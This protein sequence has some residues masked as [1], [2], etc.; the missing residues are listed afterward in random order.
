M[1]CGESEGVTV[2][3]MVA[4]EIAGNNR[5]SKRPSRIERSASEIVPKEQD[6]E[7][8]EP[9]A[10]RGNKGC[11]MLLASQPSLRKSLGRQSEV[12]DH[13]FSTASW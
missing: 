11:T 13:T 6:S 3:P 12:R 7:K 1:L 4:R 2:N 9:D 5:W 10:K 8:A